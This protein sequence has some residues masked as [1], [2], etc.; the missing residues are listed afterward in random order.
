MSFGVQ[1]GSYTIH[2][3]SSWVV[4]FFMFLILL[5]CW[6]VLFDLV[7][8]QMNKIQIRIL[9]GIRSSL[10]QPCVAKLYGKDVSFFSEGL[11]FK[12]GV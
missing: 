4:L 10:P 1:G 7:V 2:K 6:V 12:S 8:L 11:C 3:D 9:V 5:F